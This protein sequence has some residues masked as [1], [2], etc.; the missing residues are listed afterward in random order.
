MNKEELLLKKRL[1]ELSNIAY[2]RNIITFT[3]FMN[4]NELHIF[5]S[6]A[7]DFSHLKWKLY[8]GYITAE[9]QI[10]AFLPDA[11]SIVNFPINLLKIEPVN[12]KFSDTLTHR[13]FLGAVLNLGIERS[14]IGDILVKNNTGYL[15]CHSSLSDFCIAEL[16]K[17]KH[18]TISVTL[19]EHFEEIEPERKEI[20]GTVSAIRLDSVIALAFQGSRSSLANLIASGKVFVNG[21]LTESNSY[22]L[23]EGDIVS[24]RGSGKFLFQEI[25]SETKKGRIC[26]KIQKYI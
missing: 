26:I 20:V 7:Q 22:F 9:R 21:R 11:L 18:T 14:K 13:D 10:A 4:L 5:H 3:D 24:V 25:L 17:I 1:I 12:R 2:H 15:F 23:K 6:S 8:G 19:L 16:K